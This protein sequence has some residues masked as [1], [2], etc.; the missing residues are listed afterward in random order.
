[1][2]LRYVQCYSDSVS[3]NKYYYYSIEILHYSIIKHA[4]RTHGTVLNIR[5]ELL[6]VD[7]GWS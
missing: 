1:M 3:F 6:E 4:C 2:Y 7:I 5:L